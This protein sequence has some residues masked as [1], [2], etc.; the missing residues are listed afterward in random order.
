MALIDWTDEFETGI[1][2]VDTQHRQLVEIVNKFDEA[3][4]KGKGS[5]IMSEILK[6]LINYTTEHFV[7]EEKLMEDAGY[8]KLKQHRSQHRQLLQRVERMQFEFDQQGK[9]ITVEVRE[10]LKYWLISHILKED[11]AYVSTVNQPA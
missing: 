2:S 3:A 11:K 8:T 9:R 6:D 7:A 10:F 4:G 5:R 1:E